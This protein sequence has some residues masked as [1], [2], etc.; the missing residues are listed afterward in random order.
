VIVWGLIRIRSW[1][2]D[3]DGRT[4]KLVAGMQAS[5]MIAIESINLF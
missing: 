2:W 1:S 4:A 5:S 3:V